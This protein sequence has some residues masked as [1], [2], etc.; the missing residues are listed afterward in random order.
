MAGSIGAV[1]CSFVHGE[2]KPLSQRIP[3]WETPGLSGYGAQKLGL[4]DAPFRVSAVYFGSEANAEAWLVL[5]QATVGTTVTIT[6]DRSEAFANC[7]IQRVGEPRWSPAV[8]A[9]STHRCE[10]LVEGVRT[11]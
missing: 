2:C 3:V 9:S 7:L 1:S 4:G 11:A 10:V 6:N 5:V 8:N